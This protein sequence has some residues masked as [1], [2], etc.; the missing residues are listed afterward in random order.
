MTS[1]D[2]SGQTIAA[3]GASLDDWIFKSTAGVFPS[4]SIR[5]LMS[6]TNITDSYELWS[7]S[8]FGS[9]TTLS[10]I[11]STNNSIYVESS[12]DQNYNY[13]A[14]F[15]NGGTTVDFYQ[16]PNGSTSSALKIGSG[17][18][19]YITIHG[20]EILEITIPPTLRSQYKLGGN[21]IYGTI[22]GIVYEGDHDLPGVNYDSGGTGWNGVAIQHLQKSISP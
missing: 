10:Q 19:A 11:P 21:P 3:Q 17:S 16:Q 20:Q 22:N 15:V 4:G 7:D 14:L 5:Y 12:N 18:Y 9:T 8:L 13:Y 1:T 2:V 6:M